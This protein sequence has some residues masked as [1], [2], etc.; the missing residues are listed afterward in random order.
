MKLIKCSTLELYL[1]KLGGEISNDDMVF[2]EDVQEVYIRGQPYGKDPIL[3][4]ISNPLDGIQIGDY[5]T[6]EGKLIK[7]AD[8]QETDRE[9]LAGIYIGDNSETG[10]KLLIP[11]NSEFTYNSQGNLSWCDESPIPTEIYNSINPSDS[12]T[13]K[14]T[15]VTKFNGKSQTEKI[16]AAAAANSKPA[17]YFGEA[18]FCKSFAPGFKDGEWYLPAVGELLLINKSYSTILQSITKIYPSITSLTYNY[19]SSNQFSK[20]DSWYVYLSTGNAS[21]GDV[22]TSGKYLIPTIS[23]K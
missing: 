18:N 3:N 12:T 17:T 8:Y 19:W 7:F 4:E 11:A 2:V 6:K 1:N 22:A 20:G 9:N 5:V 16:L 13:S 15:V 10:G 21:S 23:I 14:D